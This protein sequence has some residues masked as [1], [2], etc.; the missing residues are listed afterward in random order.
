MLECVQQ[1]NAVWS[2]VHIRLMTS[3][4]NWFLLSESLSVGGIPACLA[5]TERTRDQVSVWFTAF[6]GTK[7]GFSYKMHVLWSCL[8][9]PDVSFKTCLTAV[10]TF[11]SSNEIPASY[12]FVPPFSL[13]KYV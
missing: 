11:Q 8:R 10:V 2:L 4:R 12:N 1:R 7:L 6:K 3:A 5:A 13:Q 9:R